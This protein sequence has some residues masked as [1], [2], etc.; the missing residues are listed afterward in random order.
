MYCPAGRIYCNCGYFPQNRESNG[1]KD[2]LKKQL[3]GMIL[4]AEELDEEIAAEGLFSINRFKSWTE[5][6]RLKVSMQ[7]TAERLMGASVA[8]PNESILKMSQ[9]G[10]VGLTKQGGVCCKVNKGIAIGCW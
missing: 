1:Y 4:R 8:E 2:R 7:E 6:Q 10:T 3:N 9:D 5:L